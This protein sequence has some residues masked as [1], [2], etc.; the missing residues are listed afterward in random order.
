MRLD[1]VHQGSAPS[2]I[3]SAILSTMM[4][5]DRTSVIDG[6][7]MQA[8][9]R[10]IQEQDYEAALRC[11]EAGTVGEEI[12]QG[13]NRIPRAYLEGEPVG[14][15]V[16]LICAKT[17]IH[18]LYRSMQKAGVLP[19]ELTFKPEEKSW[20]PLFNRDSALIEWMEAEED[21]D[22]KLAALYAQT[23]SEWAR[24]YRRFGTSRQ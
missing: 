14:H 2:A 20:G 24:D 4:P 9:W 11:I 18:V 13:L 5:E 10:R 22:F 1:I 8:M 7:W 17:M 12:F 16:S 23:I 19:D 3:T 21:M 6:H 15:L